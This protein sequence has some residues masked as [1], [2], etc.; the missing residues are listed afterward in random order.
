MSEMSKIVRS[1]SNLL[2]PFILIYGFYIILHGHLTPGGGFQGGAVVASGLVMVLVAY[3]SE[4]FASWVKEKHL[5]VL[6]SIGAL[7]F[8]SL[9][10]LGLSTAFFYNFLAGKGGLFGDI[11]PEGPNP[12]AL[13]TAGTLPLMNLAV[14]LKVIAGLASIVLVMGL[15]SHYFRQ[16]EKNDT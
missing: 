2:L 6:E 3:G 15:A 13:N 12:G 7:G 11:P 5:S 1:I 9:A 14:G 10:F 4:R 16:E 8:I